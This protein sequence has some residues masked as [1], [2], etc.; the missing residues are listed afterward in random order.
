MPSVSFPWPSPKVFPNYKRSHHWR[1]Y[2]DQEKR[3]REDGAG[4]TLEALGPAHRAAVRA[5]IGFLRLR[6]TFTPPD[7]RK[8]D[9]DGCIGAFKHYRDGMADA[10]GVD[11]ARFRCEYVFAEP[12]KPGSVLVEFLG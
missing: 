11:D 6:V 9:D 3:E 2:R 4:I 5:L 7:R 8:R 12:S 1:T 10:L